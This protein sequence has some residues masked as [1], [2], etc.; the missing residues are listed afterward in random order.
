[1]ISRRGRLAALFRDLGQEQPGARDAAGK[2]CEYRR[3]QNV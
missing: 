1:M 2:S 3:N